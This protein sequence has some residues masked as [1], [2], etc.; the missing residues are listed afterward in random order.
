ME[1]SEVGDDVIEELGGEGGKSRH[2]CNLGVFRR[3][4]DVF[5]DIQG[6]LNS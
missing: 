1:G 6:P 2:W 4:F 5:C 3:G